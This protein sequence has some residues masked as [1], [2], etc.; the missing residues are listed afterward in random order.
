VDLGA[1][2][3]AFSI[4]LAGMYPERNFLAVEREGDRVDLICRKAA[5]DHRD[6]LRA[7]HLEAG[8]TVEYLLPRDSV[9]VI[10]LLF[11]DPWPKIRHHKRRIV[12][13]GFLSAIWNALAPGGEFRFATDS[14]DYLEWAK[15]RLAS[16]LATGVWE[17]MPYPPADQRPQTDFEK[18]WTTLGRELYYLC[19]RK[20]PAA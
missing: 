18:T 1:G 5:A 16:S 7:L 15:E 19:L 12:T 2:F 10:H 11:P 14:A 6:N 4:G 8:Y 20:V 13:E 3:G 9:A 17:T